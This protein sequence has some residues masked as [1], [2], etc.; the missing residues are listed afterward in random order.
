MQATYTYHRAEQLGDELVIDRTRHR[1]IHLAAPDEER[2]GQRVGKT[3]CGRI[4]PRSMK[5]P[6]GVWYVDSHGRDEVNCKEC[7]A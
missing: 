7:L 2:N 3:A 1:T 5:Q 6:Y 4:M